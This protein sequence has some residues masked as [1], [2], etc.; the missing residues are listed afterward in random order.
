L[1][2]MRLQLNANTENWEKRG[3][4]LDK[5]APS[6]SYWKVFLISPSSFRLPGLYSE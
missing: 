2:W 6:L 3:G 5:H 4:G 1:L